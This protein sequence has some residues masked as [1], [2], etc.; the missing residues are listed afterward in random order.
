[1][2]AGRLPSAEA[3]TEGSA[4]APSVALGDIARHLGA[5]LLG[6]AATPIRGLAPLDRAGPSDIAFFAN[7]KYVAGLA[8]TGAGAVLVGPAARDALGGRTAA[9]VVDD[10]YSAFARLTQWWAARTRPR[11]VPGVHPSAV[12]DPTARL[13]AD[14]TIGPGAVV[15]GRRRAR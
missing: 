5:T 9:L 15:G 7:P 2:A 12:V 13:A 8:T 1:M 4:G 10:P 11:P 3:A 14:V 6:D